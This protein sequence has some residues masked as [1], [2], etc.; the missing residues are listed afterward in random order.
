MILL[1]GEKIDPT[2]DEICRWLNYYKKT[3][4]RINDVD[5]TTILNLC[6]SN[7][8]INFT[9]LFN[10]D[11]VT[12]KEIKSVYYRRGII[13]IKNDYEKSNTNLS[14]YLKQE[15]Y[16]L[17]NFIHIL[18]EKKPSIGKF[19]MFGPNKLKV[20]F[21]AKKV[22]L[23][24]PSTFISN[25]K[26]DYINQSK[27]H[28]SLI[29]KAIYEAFSFKSEDGMVGVSFPTS[30]VNEFDIKKMKDNFLY[31]LF[32]EN[33]TKTFEIRS[34]FLDGSIFSMAILSQKNNKTEID[35][36]NYDDKLPNRR[37]PI[38][39]PINIEKK[40]KKLMNN[41]KYNIGCIDLIYSKNEFVFLEINPVG[42]YGMVSEPCCYELEK[43]VA[44]KLIKLAD[45]E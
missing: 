27:K 5:E 13:H 32:Q 42:Q 34:F 43:E 2:L 17:I 33:I 37:I 16:N 18:L 8:E 24:I 45:G 22:G 4:K 7:E 14:Y 15:S 41:L 28:K 20:L 19:Q 3:W 1:I 10:N 9:L 44:I 23:N 29:T 36:R 31:T 11:I 38:S 30:L 25:N 35:Y 21:E 39:L 6:I 12:Y 40:L 26:K